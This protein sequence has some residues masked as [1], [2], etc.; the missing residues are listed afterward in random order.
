MKRKEK[1]L[2][3]VL[4]LILALSREDQE[5]EFDGI[6]IRVGLIGVCI[7]YLECS[8][9]QYSVVHWSKRYAHSPASFTELS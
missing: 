5:L 9:V 7:E 4:A 6:E 3:F 2:N 8:A 1:V